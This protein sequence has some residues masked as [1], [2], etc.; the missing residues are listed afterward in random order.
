[1][2]C[3]PLRYKYGEEKCKVVA[4][5]CSDSVRYYLKF[6]ALMRFL[7]R[8]EALNESFE[9]FQEMVTAAG[10][11]DN[12]AADMDVDLD[13]IPQ[14]SAVSRARNAGKGRIRPNGTQAHRKEPQSRKRPSSLDPT[15]E[16]TSSGSALKKR[17]MEARECG[18]QGSWECIVFLLSYLP[19]SL[20]LFLFTTLFHP[21]DW[22]P[23]WCSSPGHDTRTCKK[24]GAFGVRFKRADLFERDPPLSEPQVEALPMRGEPSP[25][26]LERFPADISRLPQLGTFKVMRVVGIEP[27]QARFFVEA[28]ASKDDT[29]NPAKAERMRLTREQLRGWLFVKG[30]QFFRQ[31]ALRQ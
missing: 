19:I 25:A 23:G 24:M 6:D 15:F 26:D 13:C 28:F 16:A 9:Q 22:S 31:I 1:M 4:T 29:V 3:S 14:I 27:D 17:T 30:N 18:K 21:S 12:D 10:D 8:S 20:H 5:K 2:H 11:K 7:E